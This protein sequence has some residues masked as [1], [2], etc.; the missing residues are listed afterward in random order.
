MQGIVST[1]L[2]Q[3]RQLVVSVSKFM[4]E[5]MYASRNGTLSTL[6]GIHFSVDF[7][8][9]ALGQ[10]AFHGE[11][12]VNGPLRPSSGQAGGPGGTWNGPKVLGGNDFLSLTGV[13]AC[14]T[15]LR[16]CVYDRYADFDGAA[17]LELS[18]H[19]ANDDL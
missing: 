8:C 11:N 14:S 15:R 5:S 18:S 1:L 17:R 10:Y 7:S 3:P 12:R 16:T 19:P 4:P 13:F 2:D 6:M 9:E